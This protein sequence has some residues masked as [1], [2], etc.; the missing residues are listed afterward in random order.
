MFTCKA[1]Q[2]AKTGPK[3]MSFDGVLD[4]NKNRISNNEK[5]FVSTITGCQYF[6]KKSSRVSELSFFKFLIAN[7]Y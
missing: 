6:I 4:Q 7:D 1:K 2:S 3:C 5:H